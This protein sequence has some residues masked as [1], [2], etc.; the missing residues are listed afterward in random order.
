[1]RAAP[2]GV[3]G[4]FGGRPETW[5]WRSGSASYVQS[6]S[7]KGVGQSPWQAF[8]SRLPPDPVSALKIQISEPNH[9]TRKIYWCARRSFS[10]ASRVG[11]IS[12]WEKRSQYDRQILGRWGGRNRVASVVRT[13]IPPLR[14]SQRSL[15]NFGLSKRRCAENINL[16]YIFQDEELL[17]VNRY[18]RTLEIEVALEMIDAPVDFERINGELVLYPDRNRPLSAETLTLR[19][20]I[21]VRLEQPREYESSPNK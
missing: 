20:R 16:A 21:P 2:P 14:R 5:P 4:P 6:E 9:D 18:I 10:R 1:M 13:E 12:E 3:S 19:S 8:S 15:A 11:R 17:S 7:L